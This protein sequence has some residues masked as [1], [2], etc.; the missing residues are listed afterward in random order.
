MRMQNLEGGSVK[1][2]DAI[3]VVATAKTADE[4]AP[5]RPLEVAMQLLGHLQLLWFVYTGSLGYIELQLIFAAEVIIIN[6]LS[7]P[8]YR[9]RGVAKHVSSMAMMLFGLAVMLMLLLGGYAGSSNAAGPAAIFAQLNWHDF[10]IGIAYMLIRFIGILVVALTSGD[11][12]LSWARSSLTTGG[13]TFCTMF[14]MCF[15]GFFGGLLIANAGAIAGV[16]IEVTAVLA[17]VAIVLHFGLTVLI[18]TMPQKEMRE[19]ADDPYAKADN[20]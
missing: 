13:V 19:I 9:S 11:A 7:I 4:K 10:A 20:A 16:H 8:L 18:D 14:L 17:V 1:R 2:H 6:V 15:I 3:P 5:L 12:K